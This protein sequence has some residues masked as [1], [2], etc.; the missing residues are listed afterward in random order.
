MGVDNYYRGL[1]T[2]AELLRMAKADKDVAEDMLFGVL[3]MADPLASIPWLN[4]PRFGPVRDLFE[5]HPEARTWHYC[6]SR[7]WPEDFAQAI[8]DATASNDVPFEESVAFKTTNGDHV[9]SDHFRSSTGFPVRVS[10][11]EVVAEIARFCRSVSV[12]S[13][14]EDYRED[15]VEL[16]AFYR[17]MASL[18]DVSVFFMQN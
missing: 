15:F 1:P 3:L 2:S 16:S 4:E 13:L 8:Y 5:Q 9:F 17:K 14:P 6:G 12:D 7:G 10:E 18:E 11:P